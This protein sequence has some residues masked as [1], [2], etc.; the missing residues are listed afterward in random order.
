MPSLQAAPAKN[1][2]DSWLKA[3]IQTER[4]LELICQQVIQ[5]TDDISTLVFQTKEKAR[6]NYKPGQFITLMQELDGER[7]Y[8]SYTISST[9]SRPYTL[10]LTIQRVAGGKLSPWLFEHLKP[11][12]TIKATGPDGVFNIIDIPAQKVLFLSA[13]CGITPVMSMSR[14]LLDIGSEADIRFIHSAKTKADIPFYQ[15]L[16]MYRAQYPQFRPDYILDNRDGLLTPEKLKALI[17]DLHERH[18]YICGSPEY[19]AA[20]KEMAQQFDFNMANFHQEQ[21]TDA[22]TQEIAS[23]TPTEDSN[24][25]IG[26]TYEITLTRSGKVTTVNPDELLLD[27][28]MKQQAPIVAAC[29]AGVCGACKVRVVTGEVS[30]TSQTNLTAEE[31]EQGYVIACCSTSR[32]DLQIDI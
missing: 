1:E 24:A 23:R 15:E 26:E 28:L 32:S 8:R 19:I 10:N 16:E 13:G 18:I 9:P 17:P 4:E 2:M 22:M 11:G 29:R 14:W 7:V 25:T 3:P 20:V 31:I 5:E 30:S 21:F 12:A 27:S 6:F